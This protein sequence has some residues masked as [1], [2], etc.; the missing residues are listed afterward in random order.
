MLAPAGGS[1]PRKIQDQCTSQ[2]L[3]ALLGTLEVDR[4]YS[5]MSYKAEEGAI[6]P[7]AWG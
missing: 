6:G 4:A 2:S 1:C 5:Q 3:D 7:L